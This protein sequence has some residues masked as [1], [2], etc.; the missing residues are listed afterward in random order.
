MVSFARCLST[1]SRWL[2]ARNAGKLIDNS[3][4]IPHLK[5][6]PSIY[7]STS[8][9]SNYKGYLRAKIPSGLYYA[10]TPASTTGSV[11]SE[12]I[13]ASFMAKD[14]ARRELAERM[15]ARDAQV[16]KLAPPLHVKGEKTYHLS[17]EQ[18][19][20]IVRLRTLDPY[21]YTR[22]ALAKQFNVSPLFVSIVADCPPERKADMDARLAAIKA[23]WHPKRRLAREDRKKRKELWYRA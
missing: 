23:K 18:V 21:K 13:P 16:S 11:S 2:T 5:S 20:E 14:D 3:Q 19:A 4:P 1:S 10:P 7:N 9:A 6:T 15:H 22:K 12:D 17:P 8:S